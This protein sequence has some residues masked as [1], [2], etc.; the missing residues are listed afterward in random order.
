M[1][2]N[3][4]C[5]ADRADCD[6]ATYAVE[7]VAGM[8]IIRQL[9]K[10]EGQTPAIVHFYSIGL[11][12]FADRDGH[13]PGGDPVYKFRLNDA[14]RRVFPELKGKGW[15]SIYEDGNGFVGMA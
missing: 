15:L 1:P 4:D 14:D 12:G 6:C 8:R 2:H 3:P 7:E 10:F 5:Y 9:G 11:E 13:L